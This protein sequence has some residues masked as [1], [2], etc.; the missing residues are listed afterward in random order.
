[1]RIT[2]SKEN[3]LKAIAEA[4][5]EGEHVKAV[6]LTRWLRVSAPAV[7][8][9][10][11]TRRPVLVESDEALLVSSFGGIGDPRPGMRDLVLVVGFT[12]PQWNIDPQTVRLL[13]TLFFEHAI[14]LHV[15]NGTLNGKPGIGGLQLLG[16]AP[17]VPGTKISLAQATSIRNALPATRRFAHTAILA[18]SIDVGWGVTRLVAPLGA[19]NV[20]GIDAQLEPLAPNIFNYQTGVLLHELGHQLGLCHPTQQDG[21]TTIGAGFAPCGAI[22]M[23][24]RDPGA[25]A[26]GSPA[27]NSGFFGAPAAVVNALR[28]PVDFTPGQWG[29]VNVG[30]GLAP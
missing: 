16:G 24:E 21:T 17:V 14:N 2:I 27:E 10:I 11:N 3:Y 4:A 8:M 12:E 30:A 26:M 5:S 18:A 25:T 9:A 19:G 1:M 20:S 28:R 22:P 7:T 29:L 13:K 6:T 15:D 23:A